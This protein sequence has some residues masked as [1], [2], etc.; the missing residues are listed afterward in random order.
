MTFLQGKLSVPMF[1]V[2][3][4][5]DPDIH[6]T[7]ELFLHVAKVFQNNESRDADIHFTWELFLH[8]TEVHIYLDVWKSLVKAVLTSI[9][10]ISRSWIVL[11]HIF[12]NNRTSP[13][14]PV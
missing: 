12:L 7:W 3:K 9:W 6:F 2:D 8:L 5:R 1:L 4:S 11:T 13:E 14:K 10:R